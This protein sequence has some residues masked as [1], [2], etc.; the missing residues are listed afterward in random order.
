MSGKTFDMIVGYLS[1]NRGMGYQNG[2]PWPRIKKDMDFF[3]KKTVGSKKNAIIMGRKT[4]ESIGRPLPNRKNIVITRNKG[5]KVDDKFRDKVVIVNNFNSAIKACSDIPDDGVI[6]VIGGASIYNYAIKRPDCRNIYVTEIEGDYPVDTFFPEIPNNYKLESVRKD[7]NLSF[8]RYVNTI[9]LWPQSCEM[10]YI[11]CI[12]RVLDNGDIIHGDR[13][14]VGTIATFCETTKYDIAVLN[15]EETDFK[16]TRYRIPLFTTKK[17]FTNGIIYE[18]MWFLLGKTDAKWL[19]ERNVHIWDGNSTKEFLDKRGLDYPEGVLG[20]VY[21]HQWTNWGGNWK[22]GEGGINQVKRIINLL[23]EDPHSRRAVL[24]GWNIS[25]LSKMAL[26]P[27]HMTYTFMIS[28]NRLYCKVDIRSN[29]MF[30]GHPYNVCSASI[31]TIMIARAIG[32]HPGGIGISITN[33]HIY[34]NHINQVKTQLCRIPLELP[35]FKLNYDV[36]SWDDIETLC[37]EY[38]EDTGKPLSDIYN[39]INYRSYP[40]LKGKMAV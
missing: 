13:T 15:P 22:T 35:E 29:D 28:G 11:N 39:I 1:S 31:L 19:Q 5:Y 18:L 34:Q 24:A 38:D 9:E 17:M 33:C 20:P 27:C 3:R 21:G 8:K 30:L 37:K 12:K 32:I 26:P 40:I 4:Y 7:D 10:E 2:L 23:K 16:K 25:D 14:G 36:N 6:F